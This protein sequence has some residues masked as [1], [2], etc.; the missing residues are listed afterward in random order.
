MYHSYVVY[1]YIVFMINF[2]SHATWLQGF[3]L[4]LQSGAELT[5]SAVKTQ[6]PNPWTARAFT[7]IYS[8][9]K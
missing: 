9:Y 2:F 5:P 3:Y 1:Y 4:V 8:Y 7:V 6:S